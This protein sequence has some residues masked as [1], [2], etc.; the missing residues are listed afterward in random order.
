MDNIYSMLEKIRE[1]P[2]LYLGK[3][4]LEAL[5]HFWDGYA[6]GCMVEAWERLTN[7]NFFDN[8]EK[9]VRFMS[10]SHCSTDW[11]EFNKYVHA[12]Y[13][14][15]LG[16]MNANTLIM[17]NSKSDE[18]AFDTFFELLDEFISTRGT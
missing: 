4:S 9:A 2:G 5:S 6:W 7:L 15:I 17:E 3:K 16:A 10:N 14:E 1:T 8:Y 13:N 18:D 11:F 12:H